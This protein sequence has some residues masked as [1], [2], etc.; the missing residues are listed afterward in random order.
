M[1]FVNPS[2][3]DYLDATTTDSE[4]HGDQADD[5]K[6]HGSRVMR[7]QFRTTS[8]VRACR[9][10]AESNLEGQDPRTQRAVRRMALTVELMGGYA[11]VQEV[12]KKCLMHGD[13][14]DL[15]YSGLASLMRQFFPGLSMT[16]QRAQAALEALLMTIDQTESPA[17]EFSRRIERLYET[18]NRRHVDLTAN[19]GEHNR[20]L[21]EEVALEILALVRMA[22]SALL[23]H[24]YGE[25]LSEEGSDLDQIESK[26]LDF[27]KGLQTSNQEV[28]AESSF[29]SDLRAFHQVLHR[30]DPNE[31]DAETQDEFH[32]KILFLGS[33]LVVSLLGI[34]SVEAQLALLNGLQVAKSALPLTD[35]IRL[36]QQVIDRCEQV[37]ANGVEMARLEQRNGRLP[38]NQRVPGPRRVASYSRFNL[39]TLLLHRLVA[40]ELEESGGDPQ[41]AELLAMVEKHLQAIR[42]TD[43]GLPSLRAAELMLDF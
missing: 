20:V 12:V 18:L 33:R 9:K 28:I 6:Q 19:E 22:A 39:A 7:P 36:C 25:G 13:S 24:F 37:R 41:P 38:R 8:D 14:V 16:P 10:I 40:G 26:F 23:P 42:S 35:Y 5:P 15:D 2:I 43:G 27:L 3:L 32:T 31:T 21:R 29:A 1:R 34:N 4:W 17:E 30:Y 11:S